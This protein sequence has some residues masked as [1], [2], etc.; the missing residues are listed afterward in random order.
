MIRD[1]E[2]S[3]ELEV[4]GKISA[5]GVIDIRSQIAGNAYHKLIDTEDQLVREGLIRLGW[6][7]PTLDQQGNSRPHALRGLAMR[8][9][10]NPALTVD[11]TLAIILDAIDRIP[12]ED[13]ARALAHQNARALGMDAGPISDEA[14]RDGDIQSRLALIGAA[15]ALKAALRVMAA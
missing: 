9:T 4:G 3:F 6:T 11:G 7:P 10:P 1:R 2:A 8:L 15:K 5:D 14:W 12:D 13:L